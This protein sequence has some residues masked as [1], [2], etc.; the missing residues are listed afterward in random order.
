MNMNASIERIAALEWANYAAMLSTAQA[1]PGLELHL[2][3]DVI[4]TSSRIFPTPDA[5]HACLLR[6]TPEKVETL[7]AEVKEYFRSQDLPATIFISPACAPSDLAER[8][9]RL[10]F[11]EQE[12]R[13][14][15]M[16]LDHLLDREIPALLPQVTVRPI[17]QEQV[18]TFADTFVAAFE[19][20]ADFSPYLAQLLEHSIGLPNVHHYLALIDGQTVGTCSLLRSEKI[21]VLG[22]A[23]VMPEHRRGGAATNLAIKAAQDARKQGVDTL[24]VQTTVGAWLE[25]LLRINGFEKAFTRTCHTLP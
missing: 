22:S 6:T 13:E 18:S 20:P 9:G 10:G 3:E 14:T 19:M 11:I 2:R 12:M 8:L 25:R 1:T 16:T 15:W 7:I 17:D 21:G 4:L 24:M 5:N 23:G